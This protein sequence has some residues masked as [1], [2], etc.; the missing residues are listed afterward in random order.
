[1]TP[2]YGMLV[3]GI[4]LFSN[5][6]YATLYIGTL[7]KGVTDR[8]RFVEFIYREYLLGLYNQ[9]C[10]SYMDCENGVTDEV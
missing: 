2:I 10:L 3:W 7:K 1:M 8:I 5:F 9:F 6:S 4:L